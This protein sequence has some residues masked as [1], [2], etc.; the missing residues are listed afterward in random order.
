MLFHCQKNEGKYQQEQRKSSSPGD[1][2]VDRDSVGQ[3]A[4]IL[5]RCSHAVI[6][7][8]QAGEFRV[9]VHSAGVHA[10]GNPLISI[11]RCSHFPDNAG[12][13]KVGCQISGRILEEKFQ[14]EE[15]DVL[16]EL[17]IVSAL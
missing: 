3:S 12:H 2:R 13:I 11:C 5:D 8:L 7:H 16:P 14:I 1:G 17:R 15:Q 6:M 10:D 9:L 4:D